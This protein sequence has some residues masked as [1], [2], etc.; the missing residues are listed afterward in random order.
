MALPQVKTGQGSS[1]GTVA[2]K[3]VRSWLY[4]GW[5][6]IPRDFPESRLY[7]FKVDKLTASVEDFLT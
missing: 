5:F 4:V 1:S 7:G 2:A 6:E 3:S